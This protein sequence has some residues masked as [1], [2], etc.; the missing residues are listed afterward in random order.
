MKFEDTK[1]A[2]LSGFCVIAKYSLRHCEEY[3]PWQSLPSRHCEEYSPWQSKLRLL[4]SARNDTRESRND[5][6]SQ[7]HNL[8]LLVIARSTLRGNLG[9]RLLSRMNLC[10]DGLRSAR[11]DTETL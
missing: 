6:Q 4:R 1:T 11:H 2:Q 7:W 5:T 3:S 10:S 9:L 8:S